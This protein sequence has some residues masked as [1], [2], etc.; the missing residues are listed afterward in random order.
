MLCLKPS[1]NFSSFVGTSI[2]KGNDGIGEE[3][4]CDGAY[5]VAGRGDIDEVFLGGLFGLEGWGGVVF[6]D[7][8]A[9]VVVV[10][11]GVASG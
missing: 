8:I 6:C 2:S 9:A 3:F 1:L 11:V 10:V 7:F 5:E 4:L